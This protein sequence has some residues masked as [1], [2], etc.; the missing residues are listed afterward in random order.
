MIILGDRFEALSFA[1]S[2]L[3]LKIPIIHLHG[4][5]STYASID[6]S[7]RHSITKMANFHFVS[8]KFYS[9]RLISMG[10]DPRNV[11]I[12]GSLALDNMTKM[13]LFSKK[14][15]EKKLKIKFKNKNIIITLHPETLGKNIS[16]KKIS[17][18]LESLKK[19]NDTKFI[20]TL[21]NIDMGNNY[22]FN[23]IKEFI[24]KNKQN[25]LM[26]KSM[27]QQLYFSSLKFVDLVIGNSSS[28]II[29]VP[30]FGIPSINLGDR[31]LGRLKSPSVIDCKFEKKEFEKKLEKALSKKFINKLCNN[32]N[33]Y[34]KK[35]TIKIMI[36][37]MKK[38][39]FDKETQKKFYEKKN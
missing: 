13:K 9:K 37:L 27:G 19:M 6:D 25:S 24:K 17:I 30:S 8:N 26:V 11:H 18:I 4:G 22:I 1:I 21:P 32:T 39:N 33:P 5:E 34:F 36:N 7:I 10:E 35:N 3:F 12:T 2:A 31:Q 23:T 28:G 14:E 16:K 15:L 38:I 29:E 20:F